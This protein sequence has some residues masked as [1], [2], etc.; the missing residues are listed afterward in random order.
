M[1]ISIQNGNSSPAHHLDDQ[2][3]PGH[4]KP[5]GAP[6]QITFL[7]MPLIS[8]LALGIVF[9]GWKLIADFMTKQIYYWMAV[10]KNMIMLLNPT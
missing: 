10:T 8:L 7:G 2:R 9:L 6:V 3:L 1:V 5:P 4:R